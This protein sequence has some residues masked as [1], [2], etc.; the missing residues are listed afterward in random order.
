M[1]QKHFL[2]YFNTINCT[3]KQKT[4]KFLDNPPQR[5]I[6]FHQKSFIQHFLKRVRRLFGNLNLFSKWQSLDFL[7]NTHS[8][9]QNQTKKRFSRLFAHW[10]L[11]LIYSIGHK[12]SRDF[13]PS[14]LY[15]WFNE[16]L[17]IF[18]KTM[19]VQ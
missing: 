5:P 7:F 16:F 14:L 6:H 17:L 12:F 1:I 8:T 10:N 15:L 19:I 3:T 9:I 2:K 13:F 18:N 11:M 4:N